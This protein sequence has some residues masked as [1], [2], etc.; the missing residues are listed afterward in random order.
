MKRKKHPLA[1]CGECPLASA[2]YLENA[3]AEHSSIAIVGAAPTRYDANPRNNAPF[4]GEGGKLI[5][6]LTDHFGI[7]EPLKT[8]LISCVPPSSWNSKSPKYWKAVRCCSERLKDDIKNTET[9]VTLGAEATSQFYD[10]P[11]ISE[12]RLGGPKMVAGKSIIPTYSL[13]AVTRSGDLFLDLANDFEKIISPPKNDWEPPDYRVI[14]DKQEAIKFLYGTK[15]KYIAFDIEISVDKDDVLVNPMNHQMLSIA[16]ALN[17]DEVIVLGK[18]LFMNSEFYGGPYDEYGGPYGFRNQLRE[19]FLGNRLIAWNGKFDING[20]GS[21]IYPAGIELYFDAMLASYCLDERGGTMSLHRNAIE[22]LNSPD[23]KTDVRQYK[24]YA[25]LPDSV[26]YRYNAYD[27]ANT[28]RLY[29]LFEELL[30]ISGLRSYHDFLVRSSNTLMIIERNGVRVDWGYLK[31]LDY[32]YNVLIDETLDELR[33]LTGN[34]KYNPNSW[35]QVKEYLYENKIIASNTQQKTIKK[36]GKEYPWMKEFCDLHIKFKKDKKLQSTYIKGIEKRLIIDSLY[37][38]YLLHGTV[39][40]RL[41]SRNPNLQNIPRNN[42]I[43]RMFVADKGNVLIQADYS[44]A[45]LRVIATLA[46]DDYLK[47]VFNEGRDV[48]GE[49]ARQHFGEN[50]TKEERVKAKSVVFGL[51]YDMGASHLAEIIYEDDPPYAT[52]GGQ[53]LYL[54]NKDLEKKAQK[55]IDTWFKMVWKSVEWRDS[56]E[57]K[58]LTEQELK[59]PVGHTRRF[60]LITSRNKAEIVRAGLSVLPQNIASNMTLESANRLLELGHGYDLRMLVHDSIILEVPEGI[61][62]EVAKLVVEVMEDVGQEA[63]NG[64]VPTPVDIAI[65]PS[66]GEL[67]E[68]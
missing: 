58:I 34:P 5:D 17:E 9:I 48:H 25:D 64:Y 56:I 65:G 50:Y 62:K 63:V 26:L 4:S 3:G 27:A 20:L 57:N 28:F 7:E 19:F 29:K 42:D 24:D 6:T 66:W 67:I 2:T 21:V 32:E 14:T 37:T 22:Y 41:S 47:N 10:E 51:A 12:A 61:A 18:E 16:I 36:I 59:T 15:N 53:A 23:W 52:I 30:R 43:K 11:K 68:Q 39:T 31:D 45:E 44:Q 46:K 55:F 54:S 35:K 33:K 60:H 38:N 49:L 13:G 1:K 40:G 8:N